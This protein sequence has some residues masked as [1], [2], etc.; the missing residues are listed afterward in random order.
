MAETQSQRPKRN[1][2]ANQSNG[3]SHSK[4]DSVEC[5]VCSKYFV[6]K[7]DKL[8]E[9]DRCEKW[10]CLP[11]SNLTSEQYD[12]IDD[13]LI[14]F[15]RHCRKPAIQAVKTD[16]SIE[17]KCNKFLAMF[18]SE[19]NEKMSDIQKKVSSIESSQKSMENQLSVLNENDNPHLKSK[20]HTMGDEA[21]IKE[22]QIREER[23][24]NAI[25]YNVREPETNLKDER[26]TIDTNVVNEIIELCDEDIGKNSFTNLVR[27]GKKEPDRIRPIRITFNNTDVKRQFFRNLGN[28]KSE[29]NENYKEVSV[30]HDLTVLEREKEKQLYEEAKQ[31]NRESNGKEKYRVRGPP[32]D[33]III[34]LRK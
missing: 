7:H 32:W 20:G 10:V 5:V 24:C 14:W 6:N 26:K 15:C 19:I 2:F 21:I 13:N 23:K 22:V 9:C 34:K 27:L 12:A 33:R 8:I 29:K 3:N 16:Q 25:L 1:S 30:N 28:L 11:C 4:S 31:L 18:K 17:E